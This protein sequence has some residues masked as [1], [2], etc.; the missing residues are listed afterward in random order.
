M[1]SCHWPREMAYIWYSIYIYIYIYIE[2][3]REREREECF[4]ATGHV[5]WLTFG[6][7]DEVHPICGVLSIYV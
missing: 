2:R 6:I 7:V 1:F 3:E 5:K 4:Y